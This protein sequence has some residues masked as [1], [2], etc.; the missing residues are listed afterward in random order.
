MKKKKLTER[1]MLFCRY[2]IRTQTPREAAL[3]AGYTPLF[4]KK[5]ADFLAESPLIRAEINRVKKEEDKY[6]SLK[7][8]VTSGLLRASL[9]DIGD[10]VKLLAMSDEEIL[11]KGEKLDL[12]SVSEIKRPKGG[13][14]E[15]KFIDRVKALSALMELCDEDGGFY[16]ESGFL[17]AL[18]A[19]A[20]G[21]RQ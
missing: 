19:S 7:A 18:E 16:D 4:A 17:S 8:R 15:I 2:F 21:L 11:S 3:L 9:G 10:A 13:G 20:G 6:S 12:F 5:K 1:E 14:M